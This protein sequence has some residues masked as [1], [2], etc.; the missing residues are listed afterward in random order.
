MPVI[1]VTGVVTEARLVGA[2]GSCSRTEVATAHLS[3][4]VALAGDVWAS[5]GTAKNGIATVAIATV[6]NKKGR[7][8]SLLPFSLYVANCIG[9]LR[10]R[11]IAQRKL[12]TLVLSC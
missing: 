12:A 7:L 3:V 9:Q 5:A 8:T 11:E 10:S 6:R 2:A 1:G 4:G